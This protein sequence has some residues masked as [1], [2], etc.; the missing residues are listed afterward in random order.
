M[1]GELPPLVNPAISR[2]FVYS[3]DVVDAFVAA[4]S[5]LR[6]DD[7]GDSFN[8]GTGR[9]TTIGQ[10]AEVAREL[11]GIE[12]P[13]SFT[14]P[15]RRWDVN[16]WYANSERAHK[17]LGWEAHTPLEQGLERM[18]EW[19][20]DLPNPERYRSATKEVAL[21]AEHSITAVG[22]RRLVTS[23]RSAATGSR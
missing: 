18:T 13:A 6:E 15:Q 10:L 14:M 3:D 4:A 11:Y 2:D 7:Y 5:E 1:R 20:R 12:Q 16:D 22:S 19:Y 23:R 9:Q 21:D 8:V 17:V